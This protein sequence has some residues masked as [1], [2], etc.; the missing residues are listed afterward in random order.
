LKT[1]R[2]HLAEVN[3][4]KDKNGKT[5]LE[6]MDKEAKKKT[7]GEKQKTNKPGVDFGGIDTLYLTVDKLRITDWAIQKQSGD[8]RR[9]EKRGRQNLKTEAISAAGL[10]PSSSNFI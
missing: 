5:N 7:R 1:V 3:I 10:R 2:L 8:Q 6:M 4:I 9:L